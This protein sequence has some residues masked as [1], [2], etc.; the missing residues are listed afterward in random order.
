MVI[1]D[2]INMVLLI[3][4]VTWITVCHLNGQTQGLSCPK[5][6]LH[7]MPGSTHSK[8][9]VLLIWF[10]LKS[11]FSHVVY[12]KVCIHVHAYTLPFPYLSCT[13]RAHLC[14][15]GVEESLLCHKKNSLWKLRENYTNCY[16]LFF[17]HWILFSLSFLIPC[18][19]LFQCPKLLASLLGN[20][21]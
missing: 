16:A 6:L 15:Q 21:H 13:Q 3:Y 10:I 9:H 1:S 18:K 14:A 20:C 12:I 2:W 11:C 4:T 19:S 5:N 7:D 8:F 17:S